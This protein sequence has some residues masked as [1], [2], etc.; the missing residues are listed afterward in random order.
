MLRENYY[1]MNTSKAPKVLITLGPTREFIDE[2]RYIT[3]ASSGKMGKAIAKEAIKREFSTTIISGPVNIDLPKK[4][5]K[6]L[7][8]V[9][10]K[11]MIDETLRELNQERYDILI[12]VAAI[13]DYSPKK[14]LSGRKMNSKEEEITLKLKLNPK[15]T[16]LVRQKFPNLFM[17]GFKA[18]YDVSESD[19]IKK[20]LMK[21]MDDE[22]NMVVA[23]DLKVSSFG[24]DENEVYI[25]K[26][27]SVEHIA[28]NSKEII[29]EEIWEKIL[30]EREKIK[31]RR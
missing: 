27:D 29:A 18:E 31:G 28:K 4:G 1:E 9:T 22:L 2:I 8:V 21:L 10:A 5:A 11:E 6:I 13:A 12:S 25:L 7:R 14:V 26:R 19:L 3:N 16:R 17:V 30:E 20:A 15:L 24:S 23:N